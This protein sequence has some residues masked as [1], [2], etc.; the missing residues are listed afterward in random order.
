MPRAS[1]IGNGRVNIAFDEHMNIRDFF[2]PQVGLENHVFGHKLRMG[3]WADGKFRWLDDGWDM[4]IKYLP[5][6]LVSRCHAR[7]PGLDI[8]LETND[9]VHN[10]QDVFMR[11]VIVQ[12]AGSSSRKVR[13]FFTHDFHIYGDAIG[14]TVMFEST[15]NSLIHYKRKRYFLISGLTS[16]DKG[17]FQYAT[18]QKEI[19][20]LEGTWRDAEDGLLSDNPIAQG[21][22]DSAV[23]FELDIPPLGMERAYYWIACGQDLEQVKNLNARVRKT[24]V[25]QLLLETENYWA[26][27]V[28]KKALNLSILPQDVIRMFKTSL[29]IM[30]TQIDSSG[31]IIASCDSDILQF[32][33]DTYAYNWPRDSSIAAI[34]FDLAGFQEVSRS[35]F[36][37][38][39]DIITEDGFFHHKYSTDGSVGSTWLA[40][41]DSRGQ[42][43][44]P[45]QED[46]TALVLLALW[47]HFQMHRDI[48]FIEGVYENL[49]IKA[50]GFLLG[51]LDTDT[52]LPKPSFDLWEEKVGVFTWTAAAVYAAL[53]AAAR[54]A[55]VFYDRDRQE[56]LDLAAA[57]LK[58]AIMAHL[59]DQKLGRFLKAIYPDGSRDP[60]IDSSQAGIFLFRVLGAADPAVESTMR[61]IENALW[62]KTDMG[63]LARFED[64]YYQRVSKK[65]PGNPWVICTLWLARW[66]IARAA[67]LDEL[68]K[69]MDLIYWAMRHSQPSGVMAEQIDPFNGAP[70][71]VSPLVWSHA[72]F[73]IA[74]CE[75]LDKCREIPY[76]TKS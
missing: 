71:S 22:V 68:Q 64:D 62:I 15:I 53:I 67:S 37:F 38:C 29:L 44:M 5:E 45:I 40:S 54:F 70:W 7:H 16:Q 49:V 35:Y 13:L 27:W 59:Y 10:S 69:G 26:A 34:A 17:I 65:V 41:V 36:E 1:V 3:V 2:Y 51:Y 18:G 76:L 31:A 11:K 14:D 60:T 55:R 24:G 4:D 42:L 28:N 20:S 50:T 21:S 75:Y 9:G 43:Q 33:R 39:N 56:M 72:E 61:A 12:N 25:E 30:R 19:G 46:E 32:S 73:V 66:H 48:E 63:G 57:D 6:T 52:G 58:K 23:S 47:K 8:S 74:V